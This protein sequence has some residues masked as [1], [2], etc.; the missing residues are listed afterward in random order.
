MDNERYSSKLRATD[1]HWSSHTTLFG[2]RT[3]GLF[4][5]EAGSTIEASINRRISGNPDN[6]WLQYT[7]DRHF[8]DRLPLERCLSLGCGDGA[9]ERSLSQMGVCRTC[10]AFDVAEGS[11]DAARTSA[12]MIGLERTL[13]YTL[14][15]V[16]TLILPPATYDAVWIHSAMHHFEALEY[17]C[18]QIAQTLKPGGLLILNEYVGPS[19]FQFPDRQKQV[20]NLCLQLLPTRYR[21]VIQEAVTLELRRSPQSKGARWLVSRGWDKVRDGDVWGVIQRRVSAY[22]A[23]NGNA[24]RQAKVTFPSARDVIAA[25]PSESVRSGEILTILPRYFDILE[26]RD[27]GGNIMQFL[28]SGIAGNFTDESP[29]SESLLLMLLDIESTLITCGEMTSDFS[30]IVARPRE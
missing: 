11:I 13:N 15:D 18:E 22:R 20:I 21:T 1:E 29:C 4:W 24:M 28:L 7:V 25:D 26:K 9:L 2:G 12:R 19:R 8:S 23:R 10:D 5:W 17:V 14:A 6:S 16:N 30:Y 27:W 3:S